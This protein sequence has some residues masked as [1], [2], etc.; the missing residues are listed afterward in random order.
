MPDHYP[1]TTN[2]GISA[3]KFMDG[4]PALGKESNVG[5]LANITRRVT[6]RVGKVEKV[7]AL[8]AEKITKLKNITQ[9]RKENVD[10][11]ISGSSSGLLDALNGINDNITGMMSIL[12]EQQ[13]FDRKKAENERKESEKARRGASEKKLESKAFEGLK[14]IANKVL[15]PIKS[16]WGQIWDFLSTLFLGRVAVKL[17]KWFSDKENQKKIEAVG[18]FFK[19]WWPALLTGFLLFGTGLGKLITWMGVKLVAWGGTL[20][21]KVIPALMGAIAA[22][23]PWGWAALALVAGGGSAIYLHNRNERL[24]EEDNE[25]DDESTVT[26]KEFTESRQDDDQTNDLTPSGSQLM[27][28]TVQQTGLGLMF[29]RGGQVPGSGNSD[30]VST[31]LTPGEFVVSA[32]AVQQWGADTFSAMNAMGGGGNTGSI[33]RGFSEGGLVSKNMW[34]PMNWFGGSGSGEKKGVTDKDKSKLTPEKGGISRNAKALLNTIRWA[35]GTLKPGGYNTWFGGRTDMDLTKMTIDEVVAEQWRRDKAGETTY[36]RYT[37]AAVG[38][39]QMMEP[40]VYAPMAG[41]SGSSL[42]TPENQDKMAIAAYMKGKLTN[43]EIDSPITRETIAKIAGVWASLPTMSG[44]SA[45]GQPVKKYSDLE[46][47]YNKNLKSLDPNSYSA[48]TTSIALGKGSTSVPG[49]GGSGGTGG[50]GGTGESKK[51]SGSGWFGSGWTGSGASIGSGWSG[52]SM[53]DLAAFTVSGQM[54]KPNIPPPTKPK[55]TIAYT[56]EKEAQQDAQMPAAGMSLPTI[57]DPSAMVSDSKIK[58]LGVSV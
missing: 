4:S 52:S 13:K 12:I 9:L 19:D 16:L 27:N 56:N 39:Y 51:E 29:N 25:E 45:H 5:K 42:F 21:L 30:S 8:N 18:R 46:K 31:K 43:K 17:W 23:G 38:A 24:R 1:N 3:S 7:S 48:A 11:K 36:G 40:E 28:E 33:S 6:I 44:A 49:G 41:L 47:V 35:E 14:G 10:K 58:T 50:T 20:L 57:G 54:N 2:K 37:S 32:P 26:P 55:T 22:M 53:P 34:N 15:A